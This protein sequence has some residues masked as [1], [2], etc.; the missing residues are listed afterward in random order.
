MSDF[1]K[2]LMLYLKGG[3]TSDSDL[4][5]ATTYPSFQ[6]NEETQV[7]N[8]CSMDFKSNVNP[9]FLKFRKGHPFLAMVLEDMVRFWGYVDYYYDYW[10]LIFPPL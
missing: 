3:I 6:A 1:L 7:E 9:V 10:F 2:A 4:V 5:C 8:L